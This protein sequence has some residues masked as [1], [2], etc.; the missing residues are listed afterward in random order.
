MM[1]KKPSRTAR[2]KAERETKLARRAHEDKEK[3]KVRKRDRYAC[4]FPL[5][6]CR[7]LGLRLEVSHDEHKGMGGNP[8]GDRSTADK[9][10]LFCTHRHQH[11]N[12]S[13]H[14]GTLRLVY[15]TKDGTNG[16]VAFEL[17]GDAFGRS[18]TWFEVARETRPGHLAPLE[19]WQQS[20]LEHLA[21]MED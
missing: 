14:H 6:G 17:H 18:G 12:I 3:A 2:K 15:L 11:G 21:D 8:S 10:I 19:A 16:P 13:R 1:I 5:C 9:M 7:Q 4:R 20:I